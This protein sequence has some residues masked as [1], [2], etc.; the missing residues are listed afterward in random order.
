MLLSFYVFFRLNRKL[1]GEKIP[2][3]HLESADT[4]DYIGSMMYPAQPN[5]ENGLTKCWK[6]EALIPKRK[7]TNSFWCHYKVHL[8]TNYCLCN[9]F[10]MNNGH[11][12]ISDFRNSR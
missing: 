8:K 9:W 6:N 5:I 10:L 12:T 3:S 1:F 4:L 11:D 2:L 7:I